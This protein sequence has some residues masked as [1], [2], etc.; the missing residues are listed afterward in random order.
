MR[1]WTSTEGSLDVKDLGSHCSMSE[2]RLVQ[3]SL[4]S[5]YN[6]HRID[7]RPFCDTVRRM[8]PGAIISV[9]ITQALGRV[10][11]WIAAMPISLISSTP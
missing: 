1:V 4:V 3:V 10:A 5:F 2:T 9:D 11:C 6:G 7:W 8:A